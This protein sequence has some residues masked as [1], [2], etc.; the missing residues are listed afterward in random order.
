MGREVRTYTLL[1]RLVTFATLGALFSLA[2]P[3][4][5]ILVCCIVFG[6]I[7]FLEIAQTLTPNRHGTPIDAFVKIAGG[8]AGIMLVRTINSLASVDKEPLTYRHRYPPAANADH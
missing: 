2:Y 3:H 1:E 8:A 5:T 7:V 4:H 6:A